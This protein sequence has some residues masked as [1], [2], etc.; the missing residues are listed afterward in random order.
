[1]E[2]IKKILKGLVTVLEVL[3]ICYVVLI[4]TF[5]LCRNKYGVTEIFENSFIIV[6][7]T[8]ESTLSHFKKGDLVFIK[9]TAS[10]DV[11]IK[12]ELY[13]YVTVNHKYV[14]KTGIVASKSGEDE[15]AFYTFEG[16]KKN[17][18]SADKVIGR[19]E[20]KSFSNLG[21][22]LSFLESKVGFL[23]FVIL[24]IMLLF[25]YQIYSL[26]LMMRQDK[27]ESKKL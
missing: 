13:Y 12:D 26:I 24:P 14:I 6:D 20:N 8:N 11:K 17:T 3:L 19:Y 25:I 16:E 9:H 5:L 22:I 2:S 15:S 4:T 21:G 27:L 18:V 7:K 10:K 23:I 1:M